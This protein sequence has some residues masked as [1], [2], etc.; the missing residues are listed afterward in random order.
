MRIFL[1]DKQ[2][3]I[4]E[5]QT[6]QLEFFIHRTFNKTNLIESYRPGVGDCFDVINQFLEL[7]SKDRADKLFKQYERYLDSRN[8]HMDSVFSDHLE[9]DNSFR[10][11]VKELFTVVDYESVYDWMDAN[12][13]IQYPPSVEE[14]VGQG[15]DPN[16]TYTQQDYKELTALGLALRLVAPILSQYIYDYGDSIGNDRKELMALKLLDMTDIIYSR[17]YERFILFV[18]SVTAQVENV[19]NTY[20]TVNGVGSEEQ[21]EIGKARKIVRRV[22]FIDPLTPDGI[23]QAV[24]NEIK[25]QPTDTQRSQHKIKDKKKTASRSDDEESS[26]IEQYRI[27]EE[28][29]K[30]ETLAI[31]Y[32]LESLLFLQSTEE[33][34]TDEEILLLKNLILELIEDGHEMDRHNLMMAMFFVTGVP[35]ES[36]EFVDREYQIAACVSVYGLMVKWK[37][38]DLALLAIGKRE[39]NSED[40]GPAITANRSTI[41]AELDRQLDELYPYR[42]KVKSNANVCKEAISKLFSEVSGCLIRPIYCPEHNDLFKDSILHQGFFTTPRTVSIDLAE[43]IVKLHSK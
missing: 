8:Y 36:I 26:I 12:I 16:R 28:L 22:S 27:K 9:R 19:K 24:F 38:Y 3:I 33:S 41:P 40:L 7:L 1:A 35:P 10:R 14:F 23:I 4:V 34:F 5:H 39:P 29:P 6:Q 15:L 11:I 25:N 30:G 43:M 2:S 21:A 31:S 37:K 17:P 42:R 32:Y 20:K 13:T 18:E